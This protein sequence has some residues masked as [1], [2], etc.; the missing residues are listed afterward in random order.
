MPPDLLRS[1]EGKKRNVNL[2]KQS[3][4]L[5]QKVIS[6]DL[7]R[8]ESRAMLKLDLADVFQKDS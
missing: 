5:Y 1:T 3:H 2:M 4:D 8:E 6:C 7:C